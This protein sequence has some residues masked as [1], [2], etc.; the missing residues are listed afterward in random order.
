V[1]S[2]SSAGALTATT[3]TFSNSGG[4]T[5]RGLNLTDGDTI[6]WTSSSSRV[7]FNG[8]A[9]RVDVNGTQYLG[10]STAGL[11][12]MPGTLSVTGVV[13]VAQDIQYSSNSGYG[14]LSAD[15][16]RVVAIRNTGVNVTGSFAATGAATFSSTI[17]A[18]TV[19]ATTVGAT[20]RDLY[21]DNTGLIGYVSSIRASKT[22][23]TPLT[24]TSWLDAL[25]PV[26]FNYRKKDED[27]AY[28][29]EA[30]TPLEYG[31]IAEDVEGINPEL[32]FYDETKDGLALR[33]VSYNKLM[34]PLLQRI[35]TLTARVAALEAH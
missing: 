22:N 12:T 35:Q 6:Q 25:T 27:G 14:I 5:A 20:N 33:G 15:S 19:Y 29:D 23:I 8:G 26:A 4:V 9:F 24:D 30:N 1:A 13:T 18:A 3:G 32:V 21:I 28:T 16:T 11:V 34:V 7:F 2:I 31:L 17:T 10:I